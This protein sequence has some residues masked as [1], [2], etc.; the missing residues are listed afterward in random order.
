MHTVGEQEAKG[1]TE[2]GKSSCIDKSQ[3][4][5]L[6]YSCYG[7]EYGNGTL[8]LYP[9]EFVRMPIT[10]D[11]LKD[12]IEAK[13][14]GK[15]PELPLTADVQ[16]EPGSSKNKEGWWCSAEFWMQA[17]LGMDLFEHI[18]GSPEQGSKYR[19]VAVYD[20]SQGHAAMAP[21]ALNAENMLVKTGGQTAKHIRATLWPVPQTPNGPVP[22]S[23]LCEPGCKQCL[24][25]SDPRT[26]VRG[27]QSIGVKGLKKVLIE[28]D[29]LAGC[30]NQKEYTE[31]LQQCD[32]FAAKTLCERA[33]VTEMHDERGHIALFGV[34]YHAE[35]AWIEEKWCWLKNK[36]RKNLDGTMPR[37]RNE[38]KKWFPQFKV[39][40]ARLHAR[41]CRETMLAYLDIDDEVGLAD[42]ARCVLKKQLTHRKPVESHQGGLRFA[43]GKPVTAE[44]LAVLEKV[45]R[46]ADTREEWE[47]DRKALEKELRARNQRRTR[48]KRDADAHDEGNCSSQAR[49]IR[50]IR[51]NT[52][53]MP[54][55]RGPAAAPEPVLG[56]GG[57]GRIGSFFR[58]ANKQ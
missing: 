40:D 27:Y 16:M 4:P 12:Y 21:D 13:H 18:F 38:L 43:A 57:S 2:N 29:M 14:D 42:L 39:C 6:H 33:Y 37:L 52:N 31:K 7:S 23:V 30:K 35:L 5:A 17:E 24:P 20:W 53:V 55:G 50:K 28:R 47:E 36:V 34:K 15:N 44:S 58:P 1:W 49:K 9:E 48:A 46:A 51:G 3:G 26:K 11:E 54:A 56:P 19:M 45:A 10:L 32:D 41:H 22:R 8:C 25:P